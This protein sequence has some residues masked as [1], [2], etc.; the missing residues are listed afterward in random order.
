MSVLNHPDY[1]NELKR[2][3]YTINYVNNYNNRIISEK[4]RIDKEVD[5]GLSHYNSDNAEQFNDLI[6]NTVLQDN[7]RQKLK[8]LEKASTKPYF[9]RVDFTE[10]DLQKQN[11][12]IGKMAVVRDVDNEPIV[13]DWRAPIANLYYEG[14]LG[15][16]SYDCPEGL[17]EGEIHLKRQYTIESADL[18]EIYDIDITTNDDFLQAC[19]NSSKDN[20]LKDIVST[21]QAEQN[22]VIRADMWNPLIVQGAAGGGK[23][24]I[25]LHRIAYLLYNHEKSFSPQ[26]FMIIAPNRFF[27]SYISEVLPELGVENVKQTTFEDFALEII[28]HKLKIR[29]P[30]EK[31]PQLISSGS[32]KQLIRSASK[33]KSSLNYKSLVEEYMKKIEVSFI[34]DEDFK[35]STFTVISAYELK[36]LFL[37]EYASLPMVKRLDEIKKHLVNT[38]KRKK[39]D[40]IDTITWECDR[41]LEDVRYEMK[42]CAERRARI[43]EI[44]ERREALILKVKNHAKTVVRDY[45]SKF[46]PLTVPQ[47]Y[48]NLL[49]SKELFLSLASEYSDVE[50]CEFIRYSALKDLIQNTVEIEDLAPLMY[51]R[52]FVYGLEDK[53]KVRHIIIDEAQDFGLFQLFMLKRIINSSSFTILGDLCQGIHSHRGIDN[54]QEVSKYIFEDA[55]GT[56][57]TLE[58]SYRTTIEI[59]EAAT[60]VIQYLKDPKLPPAKP[61]IRHGEHVSIEVKDSLKEI[62]ESIKLK[63]SFMKQEGFKSAAVICKTMEEC[64]SL[65]AMLKGS[66]LNPKV[67]TGSEKEYSG[68]IVIAPSYLVKG[69]EFDVVIIANASKDNFSTEELDVK[70]LYVAMTRPLHKLHIFSYGEPAEVL[71]Q[72]Y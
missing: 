32:Q 62:A 20:R 41:E 51:I 55:E 15:V 13:I 70:L 35:V 69:L 36:K 37:E 16:A 10:K 72:I 68:G 45:L 25:A 1:E 71:N 58:Q 5:Y 34:P 54:W 43:T 33:F 6:I 9:A 66:G 30:H 44:T 65:K 60:S 42:D 49:N 47:Y 61:V 53:L 14:R 46:E 40:I 27:L 57:L 24:T 50:T 2:L 23:T 22:K 26:N 21:I 64:L 31:L 38:L 7:M 3:N 4:E 63:L 12:Y 18:K 48:A 52:C 17:V 59:M 67:I 19:L 8:N 29:E 39:V 56:F 28:G 11:L